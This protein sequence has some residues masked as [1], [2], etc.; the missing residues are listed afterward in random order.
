[1]KGLMERAV[2]QILCQWQ[3]EFFFSFFFLG[4]HLKQMEVPGLGVESE[5]QLLVYT[6]AT[7][8]PDPN[9]ICDLCCSLWQCWMLNPLSETR[10]WTLILVDI[11]WVLNLLSHNGNSGILLYIKVS[12]WD[13]I[14]KKKKWDPLGIALKKLPSMQIREKPII[15]LFLCNTFKYKAGKQ[16]EKSRDRYNSVLGFILFCSNKNVIYLSFGL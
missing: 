7:V 2:R 15:F 1:M 6:T 16:S 5:L 9:H 14:I 4:L 13:L 11:S 8:T 10:D 3:G 12:T